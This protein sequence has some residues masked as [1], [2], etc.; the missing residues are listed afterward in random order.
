MRF[1]PAAVLV[2]S[3][4]CAVAAPAAGPLA[5]EYALAAVN[6]N[7]LPARSPAEP[8]VE[9]RAARLELGAD[10]RFTMRISSQ[11]DG[12]AEP[13]VVE[14]A[15]TYRREGERLV[16]MPEAG[17]APGEVEYT[18]ALSADGVVLGDER[19]DRWAFTRA[20]R[21]GGR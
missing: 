18:V 3:A 15:G 13:T 16:F 7:P 21:G 9:V 17:D 6:G 2:L 5:G 14:I 4:A 12:L 11:V 19:G 1:V 10:Q 20:R 8:N